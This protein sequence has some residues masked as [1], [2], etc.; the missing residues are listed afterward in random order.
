M[1]E[2]AK[3]TYGTGKSRESGS[4]RIPF[5]DR[6]DHFT[7]PEPNS[8]CYIWMGNLSWNGYGSIK[9]GYK[10]EGNR[11]TE[12]AH[13][14]AYEYFV[15]P[16]PK[17]MDLDHKCR[18]RCCVNPAHLEPVTRSENNKR[19]LLP[20]IIRARAASKT[21]CK[22]GHPLSGD[23]LYIGTGNRRVCRT[24]KGDWQRDKRRI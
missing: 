10:S 4:A 20:S 13:R 8:G 7:I 21:H 19:G 6:Y 16:I 15:G 17:G 1:S 3:M 14:A 24:C 2:S 5:Q 18:V 12:W 22:R 23:N 11:K 9:V